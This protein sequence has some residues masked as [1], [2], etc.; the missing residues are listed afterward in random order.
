MDLSSSAA[1]VQV[2]VVLFSLFGLHLAVDV[3]HVVGGQALSLVGVEVLGPLGHDFLHAVV[4]LFGTLL[5]T[6][7]V[8]HSQ[9]LVIGII[10]V[11][12]ERVCVVREH[13]VVSV[14]QIS[15][16]SSL[17]KLVSHRQ[18]LTR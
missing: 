18:V 1:S 9:E 15:E 6:F 4:G 8:R 7:G 11:Q 13:G 2:E 17:D 16:S 3:L 5:V 12:L 10:D 14:G